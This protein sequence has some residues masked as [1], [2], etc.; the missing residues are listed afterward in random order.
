MS[1]VSSFPY[2]LLWEE[3][4][5]VSVA[6]LA[7]QDGVEFLRLAQKVGIVTETTSYQSTEFGL[8][9]EWLSREAAVGETCYGA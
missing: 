7:R 1:D 6:N 9:P 2:D 8:D 3:R 5:L 4:Q